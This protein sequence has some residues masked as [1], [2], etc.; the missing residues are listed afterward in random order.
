MA[1]SGHRQEFH[2]HSG[3]WIPAVFLLAVLTL[4][5]LL[6]GWYLRPGLMPASPTGQSHA[7]GVSVGGVFFTIPAN[8][9]E[10]SGAG[11][12]M[13]AVTLMALFPSWR[14]YADSDA[15]LFSGNAPDSRLIRLSLRADSNSLNG[16]ARL[17]RIYRPHMADPKGENY[18]FGLTKYA[19]SGGS[20]YQDYELFAGETEKDLELLLCERGSSQFPSP[21]CLAIDRPFAPNVSFSYR[22][23]RAYLSRWREV[24]SGVEILI[25]KF[26]NAS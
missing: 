7:L 19:F 5:G 15:R 3:W 24:S 16:S 9:F 4:S 2:R 21:N 20:F 23:K 6:L 22:F 1:G 18:G 26:R 17:M 10:T 13:K 8:Y 12:E 11:S 25:A 14:G